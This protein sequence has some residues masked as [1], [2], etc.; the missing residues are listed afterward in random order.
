VTLTVIVTLYLI[1]GTVLIGMGALCW[2]G[3]HDGTMT[4]KTEIEDDIRE[5]L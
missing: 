2:Q 4:G 5:D 3:W 1:A